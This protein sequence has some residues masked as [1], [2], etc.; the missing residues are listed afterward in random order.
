MSAAEQGRA[1]R[2]VVARGRV[3]G[4]WFRQS[5]SEMARREGVDGW[6]ANRVDGT[7][8]AV[9]EGTAESVARLVAFC[10]TGPSG[11]HVERLEV[12]PDAAPEGL[13][14]FRVA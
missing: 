6:V 10:R 9:F 12:L 11:A 8:E 7:V 13:E 1:R 2:H 14:G 3:Q 5:V 4:V